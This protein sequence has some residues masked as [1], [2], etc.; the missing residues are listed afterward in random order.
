MCTTS[1]PFSIE[2]LVSFVFLE[3]GAKNS[4]GELSS[5]VRSVAA[6]EGHA[7]IGTS[8]GSVLWYKVTTSAFHASWK[9]EGSVRVSKANKPVE[10]VLVLS[11]VRI[12]AVLCENTLQFYSYPA[13]APAPSLQYA[14]I[15]GV[16]QVALDEAFIDQPAQLGLVSLCVIKR[17][18]LWLIVLD[19]TGWSVYKV[20]R[21]YDRECFDT[22]EQDISIPRDAFIAHRFNDVVCLATLSE[23]Y[24]VNLET[25]ELTPIAL[26]ISQTTTVGSARNRPSIVSMPAYDN[27]LPCF[28]ITS[29]SDHSTLGAFLRV[30]GE[31]SARLLE[32]PS[33]PRSVVSHFPYLFVL[34]R[35]NSLYIHNLYTLEIVEKVRINSSMEPRFLLH[36][37]PLPGWLPRRPGVPS[38]Q[39]LPSDAYPEIPSSS[40]VRWAP[41]SVLFV[42][43]HAL[44]CIASRTPGSQALLALGSPR[45]TSILQAPC[46]DEEVRAALQ[47]LGAYHL[48]H[49][50]FEQAQ[51]YLIAGL[52]P[53][54][55]LL[56]M[57]PTLFGGQ[58]SYICEAAAGL[59]ASL[60]PTMDE[61]ISQH[62]AWNYC[63]PMEDS[64]PVLDSLRQQLRC[65]AREMLLHV[66]QARRIDSPLVST[67]VVQLALEC[68]PK[69]SLESLKPFLSASKLDIVKALAIQHERYVLAMH[70][71]AEH[72][73]F[74]EALHLA[75]QLWEHSFHDSVDTLSEDDMRTYAKHLSKLDLAKF[76]LWLARHDMP[77][78]HRYIHLQWDAL[79]DDDAN[80]I[81]EELLTISTPRAH[82]YMESI[83]L[84][85]H[86]VTDAMRRVLVN[87]LV[88]AS[89]RDI[90]ARK[91][92]H[93][94]LEYG[95]SLQIEPSLHDLPVMRATVLARNSQYGEALELLIDE[96][97][98]YDAAE[99]VCEYGHV[100]PLHL[101]RALVCEESLSLYT[102]LLPAKVR[103]PSKEKRARL[104]ETLLHLY[105]SRCQHG[106]E[107][108]EPTMRLLNTC[109]SQFDLL[110]VLSRVP[111]KWSVQ[112]LSQFLQRSLQEQLHARRSMEMAKSLALKSSLNAHDTFWRMSR[113]MGGVVEN[114]PSTYDRADV[115]MRPSRRS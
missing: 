102:R 44:H 48:K 49:A 70:V 61:H 29:H 65:R 98:D 82:A 57:W 21:C 94:W 107:F 58:Y 51:A 53:P 101:A 73:A 39:V 36:V 13:M 78:L 112:S 115:T 67:A 7:Y 99:R 62:V 9:L 50:R 89:Q 37:P 93:V 55:M 63:P 32:W 60:A 38:A 59:W 8:D 68:D 85:G 84:A 16:V 91:K 96:A 114:E 109:A 40:C 81:W 106:S 69:T 35:D 30:D 88:R 100:L 74:S 97:H 108:H 92:L 72:G 103:N 27:E 54:A 71:S 2:E 20:R 34:L 95:P 76:C 105:L 33:H 1:S 77:Q 75:C 19:H 41:I 11:E 43:K 64:D 25:E 28:L 79:A 90:T 18:S 4:P 86:H 10:K 113:A 87:R 22:H 46:D 15:K 104:Y 17:Q 52:F 56:C 12:L 80:S 6:S 26:P 66:L 24:L 23:Y 14:P 42:C 5:S 110:Y 83:V 111:P 47:M 3:D 31:P 45:E